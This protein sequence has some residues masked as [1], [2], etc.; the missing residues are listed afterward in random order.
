MPRRSNRATLG[1][2]YKKQVT[3]RDDIKHYENLV[4]EEERDQQEDKLKAYGMLIQRQLENGQL[5]V[6]ELKQQLDP[7]LR[8]N[9]YRQA[10][11]LP[12]IGIAG[13]SRKKD[14]EPESE[15]QISGDSTPPRAGEPAPPQEIAD[16][17]LLKK[18]TKTA[19]E[20]RSPEETDAQKST[21]RSTRNSE[22][23]KPSKKALS[24]TKEDDLAVHFPTAQ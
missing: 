6:D 3:I 1:I 4:K 19:K 21:Q 11:E 5:T 17:T 8:Q 12:L 22:T 15:N 16:S 20:L 23:K 13:K 7:V 14:S 9:K 24:A 10:A 2:L 18:V